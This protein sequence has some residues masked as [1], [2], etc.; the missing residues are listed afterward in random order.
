DPAPKDFTILDRWR[1]DLQWRTGDAVLLCEA[2]VAA[3]DISRY[4]G[5]SVDGPNDR[6]HMMFSFLLNA[7]LWLAL[8]REE[9]ETLIESLTDLPRLQPLAQWATFLRKHHERDL[10]RLT[11]EQREDVFLAFA[12]RPEMRLYGRGIRRRLAPMLKGDRRR[13]ELAYA[14]QFSLPGPPALRYGEEIG[15]GE[16]LSLDGRESI[17]TPMQWDATPNGGFS[18]AAPEALFRPVAMNGR[19]GAKKVNVRAQQQDA[20]SLLRWFENLIYTLR[21]APEIG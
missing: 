4:T 6:T 21:N 3:T 11:E 10:S 19:F 5:T 9:A 15:M 13:I 17:R 12:P 20:N 1:Q 2:N 8:A 16:D 7:R 18:T 14:L